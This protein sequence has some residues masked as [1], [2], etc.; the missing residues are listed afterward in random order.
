M[1]TRPGGVTLVAVLAWISGLLQIIGGVLTLTGGGS[2]ATGWTQVVIG[3][4][5]FLVSLGLFRGSNGAR[6]LVSIV[7]VL[8][9]IT[10]VWA[11]I[12]V[13]AVFWPALVAA[14]VALIGL[15]LL[16]TRAANEFFRS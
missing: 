10:A 11:M 5:T 9:L 4:I 2:A 14:L 3:A 12:A 8:N 13:P 1:A 6:I 15:L 16:Y 7:F